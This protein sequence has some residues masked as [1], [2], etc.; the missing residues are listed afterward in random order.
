LL[1][2]ERNNPGPHKPEKMREFKEL[3]ATVSALSS[4][5]SN[6][7]DPG[8]VYD[9]V[10]FHDGEKWRAVVDSN[11]NGNLEAYPTL[12]NYRDEHKHH[13]F[14]NIDLMN[15][16]LN[17][18]DDGKILSIVTTAGS[19]GT[20]VAG[21]VGANHLDQPEAN[22]IAPGCQM[23]SVKIGDSRLG[24]ME[25]GSGLVRGLIACLENKCDLINMSYGETTSICDR[26]YFPA[27]ATE[28]VN[29]HGVIFVSSAGNNGPALTTV[30][31]PG[32][33]TDALIGVGAYVSPSMMKADYSMRETVPETQYT[34]SSRGPSYDG[35]LGV[36]IT[37]CG[38]AI[39]SV[40]NWTLSKN[41]LMNG[42]S[43]SSPAACGGLALL[44]S[45]LKAQS[46][47]YTPSRVR[48]AIE[49]TA[50][51]LDD[52]EVFAQGR[53]LLQITD[54]FDY[55]VNN[56]DDAT[57]DVRFD[58]S[59]SYKG[60]NLGRGVY[61]R[62][63]HQVSRPVEL[64]VKIDPKLPEGSQNLDKVNFERRIALKCDNK[65]YDV[66]IL[67]F[68]FLYRFYKCRISFHFFCFVFVFVFVFLTILSVSLLSFLCNL[69]PAVWQ[70][71]IMYC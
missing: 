34:W 6:Y 27:L 60:S 29:K 21:I 71:R 9:C 70:F 23:I 15:Y 44:L 14:T 35:H 48:R 24:S 32:S 65:W 64:N 57:Q 22:G 17:I 51:V 42:T 67:G 59:V 2:F 5:Q 28:L 11:E 19:H 38:G 45:G 4:I 55:L 30:G 50:R 61:L 37:A 36:C 66:F 39:T 69:L 1:Q 25:T 10:V 20:H 63:P 31:A 47:S 58:I 40:P 68:A 41:T 16:V 53:G 26:G 62:E 52:V 8:P 13:T 33:T 12:T 56:K 49:N 3:K 43:M 46:I 18:Y 54:A 7:E